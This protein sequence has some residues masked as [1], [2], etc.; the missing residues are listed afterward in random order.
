MFGAENSGIKK[1]INILKTIKSDKIVKYI[2]HFEENYKVYIVTE[3]YQVGM[4]KT[5][6]MQA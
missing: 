2:D 5:N 1:E 6:K 3:Y 4:S